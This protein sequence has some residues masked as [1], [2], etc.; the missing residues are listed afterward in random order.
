MTNKECCEYI[1]KCHA[2]PFKK[3]PSITVEEFIE[4]CNHTRQCDA[5]KVRIKENDKLGPP[6]PGVFLSN[7]N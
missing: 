2:D 4:I 5:C 1:R 3:A 7:Q 6:T